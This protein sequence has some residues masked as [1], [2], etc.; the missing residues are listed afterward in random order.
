M[1]Y[2]PSNRPIFALVLLLAIIA[3]YSSAE[4]AADSAKPQYYELRVYTTRS[5]EQQKLVNDYWQNSAIPAYNRMGIQPI[6][7]F[8]ELIDSPTSKIYVLIPCDS[9][10]IFASIPAKLAADATY[11][12]DAAGYMGRPKSDPPYERFESSLNIAFEAMK[13]LSVPS[14]AAERK[15]WIF[16]LRTYLSP[17]EEKGVNKVKMFNSGEVP[18]MLQ[19]GLSPVFFSRTLVGSQMPN[20]VYM[21][22][23]ENL[24]EHKKHWKAFGDSPV[25]KKL[26]ADPQYKDNVSKTN[27]VFLKRAPASQ[28]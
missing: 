27:S 12:R 19:V 21:V 5:A 4:A 17:T 20:L 14:S 23:G 2:H 11:Q 13:K 6:G 3:I 10:D 18:L 16:E 26:S 9:L 8:T 28:I 22:S 25:W 15:A 7:V 1:K 24:E